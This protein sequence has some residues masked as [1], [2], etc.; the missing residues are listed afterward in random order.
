V[1]QPTFDWRTATPA[2]V[3]YQ[4]SPSQHAKRPLTEYLDEYH[5]LSVVHDADQLAVA[6]KPLLIYI[7]GGYWQ[8]LSAA[9]SLFNAV[10]ALKESVSLHAVEYTIA[11]KAS[12][13][14]MIDECITDVLETIARLSSTHVVLAGCSAGAHLAAMCG[15]HPEV[16]SLLS[17]VVLLSGIYDVRPLVVTP[18]NDPLGLNDERA[19]LLSPQLLPLDAAPA[20]ALL[21]VG[22][23]ESSE[24]IRQNNEYGNYL[25]AAGTQVEIAVVADRDHFDL[26][27][28]LLRRGTL[29]GDWTLAMLG[30]NAS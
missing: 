26:P 3:D 28:D 8:K 24:F 30:R 12:I 16:A 14:T 17:G 21:A 19:A 7:H 5:Q 23:Y 18:T 20:S 29:V 4:Y 11:P 6:H 10:D 15:R 2:E 22:E 27:Y 9:D 25:A 13:E 1:T